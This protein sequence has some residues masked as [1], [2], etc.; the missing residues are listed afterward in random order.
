MQEVRENERLEAHRG[1]EGIVPVDHEEERGVIVRE[2]RDRK[3]AGVCV[4]HLELELVSG[5]QR[6]LGVPAV[7]VSQ[8][9]IVG[10]LPAPAT[11]EVQSRRVG[12]S[13]ADSEPMRKF[14]GLHEGAFPR[15]DTS[16]LYKKPLVAGSTVVV[17]VVGFYGTVHTILNI[18]FASNLAAKSYGVR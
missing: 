4:A 12:V 16:T 14:K 17:V 9:P 7:L 1:G 15:V 10:H 18:F 6:R 11:V 8:R 3:G 2:V 13:V 5:L